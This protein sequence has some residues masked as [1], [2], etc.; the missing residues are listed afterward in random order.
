MQQDVDRPG[1]RQRQSESQARP[2]RFGRSGLITLIIVVVL[3]GALAAFQLVLKPA[4][5]KG[6]LS[7][8][9]PPPATISTEAARIDQWTPKL[10]SVGSLV[11]VQ[12]IDIT[13]QVAGVVTAI[14]FERPGR[15]G[16][17]AA[18]DARQ[19]RRAGR[20]RE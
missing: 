12:G 16:G 7:K 4:M 2:R 9:V 18:G 5:I 17:C 8:M 20:S 3:L 11:A 1:V 13:S 10:P 14:N 19:C 15:G 6:F